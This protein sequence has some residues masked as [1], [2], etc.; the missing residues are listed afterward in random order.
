M[1]LSSFEGAR[2]A[3]GRSLTVV[4][5]VAA[6]A[7]IACAADTAGI[8]I[9]RAVITIPANQVPSMLYFTVHNP[10]GDPV[11]L[12][13]AEVESA[14]RAAIQSPTPHR[15][16]LASAARGASALM[17]HVHEVPVAAGGTVRFTPGGFTVVVE[18]GARALVPGDSVRVT[19]LLAGGGRASARA[20]LVPYDALE[21]ALGDDPAAERDA[22]PPSVAA[23]RALY[24]SDGCVRCHGSLGRGDGPVGLTLVPPPRDFRSAAAFKNGADVEAIARTLATGI[25]SG[26]AMPLYAHLSEAERR[27]LALY[28]IS[29]RIPPSQ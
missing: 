28:V 29:L 16:P 27:S 14:V 25:P 5:V 23:G 4:G 24:H 6:L 20:L 26:G 17:S 22:P 15:M 10:G 8:V 21:Q 11:T 12:V 2:G 3:R 7:G 13:G 18:Q 9:E 1:V 19:L